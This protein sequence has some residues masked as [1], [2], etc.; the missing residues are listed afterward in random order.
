MLAFLFASLDHTSMLG[1]MW[2]DVCISWSN[3]VVVWG[4]D[5]NL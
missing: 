1:H 3:L 4:S 5:T 2:G